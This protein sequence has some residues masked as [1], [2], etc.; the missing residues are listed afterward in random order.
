MLTASCASGLLLLLFLD[1]LL[2]FGLPPQSETVA[3]YLTVLALV[4]STLTVS[5]HLGRL[6]LLLSA[7]YLAVVGYPPLLWEPVVPRL[8]RE[9]SELAKPLFNWS[10][11]L[12]V[13]LPIGCIETYCWEA[14]VRALLRQQH[15]R[16]AQ[17]TS[18]LFTVLFA[19]LPPRYNLGQCTTVAILASGFFA[20]VYLTLANL[21][22][23]LHLLKRK[24]PVDEYV[25]EF[26]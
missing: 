5:S 2:P 20:L 24:P 25:T 15:Y 4:V 26:D 22:F 7:T 1:S 23:T 21:Q 11:L 8:A 10:T 6:F 12:F 9:F 13:L 14:R 3:G 16:I 18:T 17:G 19:V